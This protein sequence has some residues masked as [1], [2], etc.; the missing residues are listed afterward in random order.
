MSLDWGIYRALKQTP[1]VEKRA[2]FEA[3]QMQ[4]LSQLGQMSTQK[5][6]KQKQNEALIQ[7]QFQLTNEIGILERD[8]NEV[9]SLIKSE[10]ARIM[11][12]IADSGGD[13][14]KYLNTG[15]Q[16]D[17]MN[18]YKKI[19]NSDELGRALLNK[20]K[21]V[22][23]M[24]SLNKGNIAIPAIIKDKDGQTQTLSFAEQI[25]MYNN[26]DL[27]EVQWNGSQKPVQLSPEAI[28]RTP[29]PTGY[30]GRNVSVKEYYDMLLAKGQHPLIAQMMSE[31]A[32]DGESGYTSL[33]F[34]PNYQAIKMAQGKGGGGKSPQQQYYSSFLQGNFAGGE[35]IFENWIVDGE[36]RSVDQLEDGEMAYY[37]NLERSSI[38]DPGKRSQ[39]ASFA[40]LD[41]LGDKPVINLLANQELN[42]INTDQSI[43]LKDTGAGSYNVKS[44]DL[45]Y[46][47]SG[48][49]QKGY[50]G[51]LN[52][53]IADRATAFLMV[54]LE[55]MEDS[56]VEARF[57]DSTTDQPIYDVGFFVDAP[58]PG[59]ERSVK[60]TKEDRDIVSV[61][62]LVPFQPG[63]GFA[64]VAVS[65]SPSPYISKYNSPFG[66]KN[67]TTTNMGNIF[68]V[69]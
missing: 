44:W 41:L 14:T 10:E 54:T 48:Q 56:E 21:Q 32:E 17:L 29:N 24:E 50:N 38:R 31:K 37:E 45:V 46:K 4:Y 27:D 6:E 12:S 33:K 60:E 61:T 58:L 22:S 15:G 64:D 3:Q 53:N 13:P 39:M 20:Q 11:K 43:R 7:Q 68:N 1:V 47:K 28:F 51:E 9:N 65:G 40:G 30:M 19:Q 52:K 26:G 49:V 18:Y 63:A 67:L 59:F 34:G 25:Q 66:G 35:K 57:R 16:A 23:Y 69:R 8:K 5:Q 42:F 62:L 2:A 55:D 36:N